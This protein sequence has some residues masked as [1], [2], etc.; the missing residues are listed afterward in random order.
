MR[1]EIVEILVEE[2]S[3]RNFLSGLLPRILPD[4][5]E[6]NTNCFIRAHEG[7]QDLQ[8]SIPKKVKAFQ[9]LSK[10]I[11]VVI[12][13]DQD[14]SD[15]KILKSKLQALVNDNSRIPSLVRIACRELESWYLGDMDAIAKVYPSFNPEKY[16][17]KSSFR[18]P[19]NCNASNELTK[20]I[21]TFQKGYASTEMPNYININ[22]NN[23]ESFRQF[24]S[25]MK[26]FLGSV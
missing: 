24:V 10:P 11:K 8:K 19:D 6:L 12:I 17:R 4:G 23:S 16:S 13:Q 7:K 18:N 5:Y 22:G 21:P 25:G 20:M 14:S 26:C 2:P 1:D 15:C 3:M 9:S